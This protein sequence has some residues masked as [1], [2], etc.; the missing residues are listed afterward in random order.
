MQDRQIQDELDRRCWFRC[1]FR[2]I[3]FGHIYV[4]EPT[5]YRVYF[6]EHIQCNLFV[7]LRFIIEIVINCVRLTTVSVVRDEKM[8]TAQY[9]LDEWKIK[10][11]IQI[12]CYT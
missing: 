11:N 12:L 8:I 4:F 3:N 7:E 9:P 5:F 6:R 1:R 10:N 2:Q